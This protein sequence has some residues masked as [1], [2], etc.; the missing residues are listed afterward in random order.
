MQVLAAGLHG[1]PMLGLAVLPWGNN[2]L[3]DQELVPKHVHEVCFDFPAL[4]NVSNDKP[5][6]RCW[7]LW[8]WWR[9]ER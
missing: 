3:D 8:W 9:R 1:A 7:R 6:P 2:P 4:C 5:R